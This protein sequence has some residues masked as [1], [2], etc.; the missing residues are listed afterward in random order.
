MNEF[1]TDFKT[2]NVIMYKTMN[3]QNASE[4]LS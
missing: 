3:D 2:F 1:N 4:F